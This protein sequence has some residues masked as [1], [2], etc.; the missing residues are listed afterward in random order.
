MPKPIPQT[1]AR[2]GKSQT[3]WRPTGKLSRRLTRLIMAVALIS[4]LVAIV[5]P[6]VNFAVDYHSKMKGAI[7]AAIEEHR[8]LAIDALIID[9][10]SGAAIAAENIAQE[11]RAITV[12]LYDVRRDLLG[13][14]SSPVAAEPEPDHSRPRWQRIAV[15]YI[16]ELALPELTV[17]RKLDINGDPVGSVE[18]V[19]STRP[20]YYALIE[21]LGAA[22]IV[23]VLVVI[24]AGLVAAR[25][26][27]RIATPISRLL[28]M[29]D[30]VAHTK[31]FSLQAK[32][33]GPDEIG[34][35]T[36]S[37]NEMLKQVHTRNLA[38]AEHRRKLQE[39]V[40]DRT[41][42]F[43]KA[44][45]EAETASRAKGDFLARM[46]HEI[47]TPMNGVVGMAELLENTR[48]EEQQKHMLQ[49]MR[50]SADSLLD[51]INDILD[52]SRI[53]AGQLQ[54]LKTDFSPID[55]IEEV[56]ELLAPRA[57]ERNLEFICD[58]DAKVPGSCGGDPLR[59]RQIIINLLGNAIKYTEK[60]QVILRAMT[61]VEADDRVQLRVEVEDTGL[62]I[63]EHQLP[64]MFEA[65]TQGDSFESRKHGGTGLGLAITR[66]L[67][68]LL[69]GEVH[70]TSTLGVG[71]KFWVTVPL[72]IQKDAPAAPKWDPGVSSV[73][74]V[75]GDGPAVR[76]T[77]RFFET[78][79]V[80]V[81][82]ARSGHAA[83]DIMAID[84]FGLVII[85]QVLPDMSGRELLDRIRRAGGRSRSIAVVLMTTTRPALASKV[86]A[87]EPD[88]RVA[89]PLRRARLRESVEQALGRGG[90]AA[91][92]AQ[93]ASHR[94]R[95]NIRVLLVEDSPVNREV[96]SGMLESIGCTVE[97][98]GDG[99]VGIEQA[100]SWGFDAVLMD[101]Q[102]PLVDGFE[103]TRR[104]RA[105][106]VANGRKPMP[107][108]A[109]TANALQ[110]DRERCLAA[111]M[112]DFISKPFTIKKL[113][114]ALIAAT[115]IPTDKQAGAGTN[116]ADQT[117]EYHPPMIA[118]ENRG[119][120][121]STDAPGYHPREGLLPVVDPK[122]MQELQAIGRP[123]LV[124]EAIAF[125]HKQVEANL[126][127]LERALQSGNALEIGHI[128]H[129]LKSCSLSVGARRFAEAASDCELAARM[130]D[131]DAVGRLK[132]R[133]RPE[134]STLCAALTRIAHETGQAA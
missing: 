21:H 20:M 101:C 87:S 105:A 54:V 40:I 121:I 132:D 94:L 86:H 133:L 104:I 88:A 52:F 71:S 124:Q 67:V 42:S 126:D 103:A 113:H 13:S 39:L 72:S 76:V 55:L 108:I 134:Y 95:L 43:E 92:A 84:D 73:L 110:G 85:D 41:K 7:A 37:F 74:V 3:T 44:A 82:T 22:L 59:L 30:A 70:V 12:R 68:T 4:A 91:T 127:E 115:G 15:D 31:N 100:L 24:F 61:T 1:V 109:L 117:G 16:P 6:A 58:I 29:M 26:C 25:V 106:E 17:T 49:T 35:L 97:T 111:G 47:R 122:Q 33:D 11:A 48:L 98:A 81:W 38:L 78:A 69:G 36:V 77:T 96:A 32:P 34:R 89:K 51:I 53:E 10:G 8:N 114:T 65:F 45:R 99:S 5:P 60:G 50:S 83:I 119:S 112:T 57:H 79:G 27:A 102:M 123:R 28:D 120:D 14:Y 62:G 18:V 107:I 116:T 23:M 46:S 118:A 131:L 128:A 80:R 64:T 2:T 66:Q 75:Q 56:C 93:T 63:A 90:P 19:A 125:F 9:S 129:A 130:G